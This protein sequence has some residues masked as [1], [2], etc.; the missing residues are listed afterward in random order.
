MI[1]PDKRII[2]NHYMRSPKHKWTSYIGMN[3]WAAQELQV[4]FPYTKDSAIITNPITSFGFTWTI[5]KVLRHEQTEARFMQ[6]GLRYDEAHK[7]T[8]E[9]VGSGSV[10]PIEYI[11]KL[12]R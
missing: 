4:K 11:R 1:I 9:L 10:L 6:E 7:R 12:F 5:N 8:L 3:W 2:I